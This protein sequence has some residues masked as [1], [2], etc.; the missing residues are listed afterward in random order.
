M[1]KQSNM[2]LLSL[3]TIGNG[4]LQGCAP[5]AVF[6]G[7]SLYCMKTAGQPIG[8]KINVDF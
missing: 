3:L 6:G 4:L 8:W 2:V 1:M 7:A 5:V